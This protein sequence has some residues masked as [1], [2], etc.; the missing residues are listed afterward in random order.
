MSYYKNITAYKNYLVLYEKLIEQGYYFNNIVLRYKKFFKNGYICFM[1]DISK[2]ILPPTSQFLCSK[3]K[4]IYLI[5]L[6]MIPNEFLNDNKLY[7]ISII[8][9]FQNSKEVSIINRQ[10]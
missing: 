7:I 6:T 8:D 9:H 1:K 5:D 4:E 2:F 10:K 3:P